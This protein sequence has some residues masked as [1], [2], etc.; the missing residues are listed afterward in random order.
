[1]KTGLRQFG[2]FTLFAHVGLT[3]LLSAAGVHF[4]HE[5]NLQATGT[6]VVS[7]KTTACD[8]GELPVGHLFELLGE[9]VLPGSFRS[10]VKVR[11]QFPCRNLYEVPTIALSLYLAISEGLLSPSGV[12]PH[13]AVRSAPKSLLAASR[14]PPVQA[15]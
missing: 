4:H 5:F 10:I 13:T 2:V 7:H 6:V 3:V 14:A 12:S 9:T 1:M 8:S 11:D 15:V